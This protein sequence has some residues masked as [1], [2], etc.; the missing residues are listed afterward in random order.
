MDYSYRTIAKK[1]FDEFIINKSRFIGYASPIASEEEAISFIREI[2]EKHK[3]ATHNVYGYVYGK[4][5]N[6]Q[7][8]SDDGEPSGT[9]GIPVLEV[10]KKEEL[11]NLVVVVTRYFGGTK[12]GGGGLI[13][14]YTKSAKLAIDSSIIVQNKLFNRLLIKTSYSSY[15]KIENYF[16]EGA[17]SVESID[18]LE[19]VEIEIYIEKTEM[20]KVI[21][22]LMNITSGELFYEIKGGLYLP[23]KDGKRWV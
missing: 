17:Y 7:R 4:E 1:G 22:D 6:I 20:D 14:A 19:Q 10:I 13:R 21:S 16:L 3:D 11:R 9:A 15:G 23:V 5:S 8:F 12:L 2:K 18:F